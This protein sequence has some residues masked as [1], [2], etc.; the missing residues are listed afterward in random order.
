MTI[1]GIVETPYKWSQP[2]VTD[3]MS[4]GIDMAL[5]GSDAVLL[6]RRTY[7]IFS[8][9]WPSQGSDMPMADFLNRTH[10]Y[11]V[12]STLSNLGWGPAS[13]LNG[14]FRSEIM[15]LKEMPGKSIQVPGSPTLVQSL[16]KEGLLDQLFLSICPIAVGNGL[17]LFEGIPEPL[18]L[19]LV[20]SRSSA[21]GVIS[22]VYSK[23][24]E[25]SSVTPKGAIPWTAPSSSTTK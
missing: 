3:D 25:Q 23:A 7:E 4:K 15:K 22:A 9:I 17:R 10:K 6:G 12:S 13:L 19:K 11:V 21:T 14:E 2:Y 1:D 20:D 16:M 5:N 8:N 18:S 24:D